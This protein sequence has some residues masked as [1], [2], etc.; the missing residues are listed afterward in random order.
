MRRGSPK[1]LPESNF[2]SIFSEKINNNPLTVTTTISIT[3]NPV[4]HNVTPVAH[5]LKLVITRKI[6]PKNLEIFFLQ[7]NYKVVY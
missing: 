7:I 5:G 1:D 2:V 6:N 3:I 4:F